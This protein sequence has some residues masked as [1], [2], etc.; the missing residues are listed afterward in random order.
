MPRPSALTSQTRT[1]VN[2]RSLTGSL[3]PQGEP[4]FWDPVSFTNRIIP[5][6]EGFPL[7]P[8]PPAQHPHATSGLAGVL[9]AGNAGS[10]TVID[11]HDIG[12]LTLDQLPVT[13]EQVPMLVCTD[14]AGASH[15]FVDA[16]GQEGIMFSVGFPVDER[17]RNAVADLPATA[18]VNAVTQD[19]DRRQGAAVAELHT[20]GLSGWPAALG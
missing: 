3:H 11:H 12:Q 20:L 15:G 7:Q 6:Q 9:R 16:L 13:P 1:L 14:A 4:S 8:H 17:V 2:R 19:G 18:W 10:N 5:G